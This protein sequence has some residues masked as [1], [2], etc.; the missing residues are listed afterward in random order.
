MGG[1]TGG[2]ATNKK[3]ASC[4]TNKQG[5]HRATK[6]PRA[7][8]HVRAGGAAG[9]PPG[10]VAPNSDTRRQGGAVQ[11]G[12]ERAWQRRAGCERADCD[13]NNARVDHSESGVCA[14][15]RQFLLQ[16]DVSSGLSARRLD[17]RRRRAE[18][19]FAAGL[20]WDGA[21]RASARFSQVA[22]LVSPGLFFLKRVGKLRIVTS[23]SEQTGAHLSTCG[24][25]SARSE[26]RHTC[27]LL[28]TAMFF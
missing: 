10:R 16:D 22:F 7:R 11:I 23:L 8:R 19:G 1:L 27:I 2:E 3:C 20:D 6:A 4:T 12:S 15:S 9:M 14:S 13:T 25:L 21:K 5:L 24:W 26:P 17:P 28:N 18:T